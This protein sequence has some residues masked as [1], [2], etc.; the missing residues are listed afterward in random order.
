MATPKPKAPAEKLLRNKRTITIG[1][2]EVPPGQRRSI[3]LP[4]TDLYTH[5]KMSMPVEVVNGRLAG[6][7]L[8]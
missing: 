7:T 5:T 2:E 4:V 1:T 6:P 3:D 8:F